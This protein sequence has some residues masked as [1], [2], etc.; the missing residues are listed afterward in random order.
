MTAQ[1]G[2]CEGGQISHAVDEKL[3]VGDAE[4]LFQFAEKRRRWVGSTTFRKS[5]VEHD[6]RIDIDR[7]VQPDFAF[8][9]EPNLLFVDSNAIRF[10][11]ERLLVRLS[12]RLVSVTD[13]RAAAIDT[14][15]AEHVADFGE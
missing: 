2:L 11:G 13:S 1:I 8:F 15:P 4:F 7:R 5:C 9:G 6:F 14:E 10:G 12:E 3:R